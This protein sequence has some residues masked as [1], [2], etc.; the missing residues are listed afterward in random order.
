M[1][2]TNGL[3]NIKETTPLA[4]V[5]QTT[6]RTKL[7]MSQPNSTKL[8]GIKTQGFCMEQNQSQRLPTRGLPVRQKIYTKALKM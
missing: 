1:V 3:L 4:T 2:L 5:M 6:V 8:K 7:Y